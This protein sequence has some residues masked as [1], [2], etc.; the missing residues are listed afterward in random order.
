MIDKNI[1]KFD[2]ELLKEDVSRIIIN[3]QIKQNLYEDVSGRLVELMRV[4]DYYLKYLKFDDS[5]C[6]EFFRTIRIEGV[7]PIYIF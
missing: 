2:N 1:I 4:L 5:G 6:E 7:N 3:L